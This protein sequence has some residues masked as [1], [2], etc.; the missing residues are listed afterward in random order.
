MEGAAIIG[1]AA[2]GAAAG[3]ASGA[4]AAAEAGAEGCTIA[5][6]EEE[7]CEFRRLLLCRRRRCLLK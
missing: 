3:V 6:D 4:F 2:A 5:R 1:A 7:A